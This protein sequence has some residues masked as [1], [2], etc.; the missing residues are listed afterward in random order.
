M[1]LLHHYQVLC[2]IT[3]ETEFVIRILALYYQGCKFNLNACQRLT[4]AIISQ[5][6]FTNLGI[7]KGSP[8]YKWCSS[9]NDFAMRLV[10]Q[11]LEYFFF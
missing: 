5:I 9:N 10:I 1:I 3:P 4:A 11:F 6:C 7:T 2:D 8:L